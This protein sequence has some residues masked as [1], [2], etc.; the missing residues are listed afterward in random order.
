MV[1]C[2]RRLVMRVCALG[3]KQAFRGGRRTIRRCFRLRWWDQ[4]QG[5]QRPSEGAISSLGVVSMLHCR[6]RVELR[7]TVV[8]QIRGARIAVAIHPD[9]DPVGLLHGGD[10]V[11]R[12]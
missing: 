9:R 12:E 6:Q 2:D 3:N 1:E 5:Q 8:T 10:G 4:A 11:L 7:C